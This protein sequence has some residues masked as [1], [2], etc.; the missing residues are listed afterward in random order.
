MDTCGD[1]VYEE[2]IPALNTC[3]EKCGDTM[4]KREEDAA[5]MPINTPTEEE[6]KV[7]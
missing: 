2:P 7:A 4:K 6:A 1:N 3:L 5:A